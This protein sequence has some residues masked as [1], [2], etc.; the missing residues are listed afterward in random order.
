MKLMA[1]RWGELV[2]AF[3]KIGPSAGTKL[4]TPGGI[5]TSS[6]NL[7]NSSKMKVLRK[8]I[9]VEYPISLLTYKSNS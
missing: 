5:P 8:I 4:M 6:I 1:L 7:G 2:I 9:L 3:P